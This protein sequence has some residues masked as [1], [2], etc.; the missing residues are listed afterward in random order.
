MSDANSGSTRIAIVGGGVAGLAT[1]VNLLD[2]AG[3]SQTDIAVTVFE[4]EEQPGGNLRTLRRDGWQ[5]EWGPNGFLD[6]EPATLRLVERLLLGERLQR[7]SDATRRRAQRS[8]ST[9]STRRALSDIRRSH[10]QGD[11]A[12]LPAQWRLRRSQ[13]RWSARNCPDTSSPNAP[14]SPRGRSPPPPATSHR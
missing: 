14:G 3:R 13:S 10:P 7:S 4:K 1:A 11:R 12:A 8:S 9:I 2:Q 5:L 6:N